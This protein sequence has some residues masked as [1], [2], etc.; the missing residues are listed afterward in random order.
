MS[1]LHLLSIRDSAVAAYMPV[2]AV[3]HIAGFVRALGDVVSSGST[4]EEIAKHPEDYVVY[5]VGEFDDQSGLIACLS[6]PEQVV[7]VVDL[8]RK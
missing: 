4:T 6:V 5:K 8:V 7:R 1:K 3:T 2:Q